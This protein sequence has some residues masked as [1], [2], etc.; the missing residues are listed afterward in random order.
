MK[1]KQNV[2]DLVFILKFSQI[3]ELSKTKNK[4]EKLKRKTNVLLNDRIE[5]NQNLYDKSS[6]KKN[7]ATFR[8][9][10]GLKC[11]NTDFISNF[12]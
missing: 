7:P 11:K 1:S 3:I 8:R 2:I 4:F 12:L 6:L 9:L 5:I 10:D